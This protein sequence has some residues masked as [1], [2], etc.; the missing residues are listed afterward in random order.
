MSSPDSVELVV[1]PPLNRSTSV[2]PM[3][4]Y[5]SPVPLILTV[6]GNTLSALEAKPITKDNIM[7]VLHVIMQCIQA[8]KDL[9]KCSK[10]VLA[11]DCLHWMVNQQ[12]NLTVEERTF[13]LQV[14]DAIAPPAIDIIIG[15]ANGVSNLKKSSCCF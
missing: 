2:I 5:K 8:V 6:C 10:K 13:L 3:D 11:L 15:V 7:Q 4:D 12:A 9:Q 1:P 14:V